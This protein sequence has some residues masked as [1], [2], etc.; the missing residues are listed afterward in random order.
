M[1]GVSSCLGH[2]PIS[3]RQGRAWKIASNDRSVALLVPISGLM[4]DS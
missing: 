1:V 4:K 3:L 2:S